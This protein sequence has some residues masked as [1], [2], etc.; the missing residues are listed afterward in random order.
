ME[1][2]LKNLSEKAILKLSGLESFEEGKKYY[3]QGRVTG[4]TETNGL[5]EAT[6]I[7]TDYYKVKISSVDLSVQCT[8]PLFKG[9]IFCKHITA[10]LFTNLKGVVVP[11]KV[12]Q[13]KRP[14]RW[15]N[16]SLEQQFKS[17]I[18]NIP[19]E[20]LISDVAELGHIHPDIEEYFIH[21]YS[22]KTAGFYR[23]LDNQIK[24]KIYSILK[25]RGKHDFANKIFTASREVNSIIQNLPI[26]R[27]SA[28]FLLGAGFWISERLPE[29]NDTNGTL[30]TLISEIIERAC[31]Y[32]NYAVKEDLVLFYQYSSMSSTFGYCKVVIESILRRVSNP[33][34]TEAVITKLEKS[35]YKKD[36][37]FCFSEEC[38]W[39]LMMDYLSYNNQ[40]RYEELLP[41][42]INKTIAIKTGYLN[43]LYRA[44]RYAE[45]L[46]SGAG[47]KDNP[48]ISPAY[49]NSLLALNNKKQIVEYYSERLTGH[50]DMA[51][52]KRFSEIDGI[53]RL[54]QWDEL[55]A[56][57]L[58]AKGNSNYHAELLMYLKRYDDFIAFISF[59]GEEFYRN[60]SQ[61]EKYAVIFSITNAPMAIKLYHYLV[62]RELKKISKTSRYYTLLEY[63]EELK[64]L[65]DFQYLETLKNNLV[66]TYPTRIKL[67]EMLSAF[68][69]KDISL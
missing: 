24:V 6:V 15:N 8:C 27:H 40:A 11:R 47:L 69:I 23:H 26:S 19:R 18:Q 28:E 31:E 22:E 25:Y 51:T 52:F 36:R 38:G 1:K 16:P 56:K 7:G 4:Y 50:F 58:A 49:E 67:L 3:L 57:I 33:E 32:L 12:P 62:D 20:K 29:I 68:Q 9:E 63:F 53:K 30:K 13:I 5:L 34:I 65:N 46:I 45:V 61:I 21:K 54:P 64:T 17:S 55:V 41:E 35:I 66:Q 43:Y 10:L 59:E 2:I 14:G 37:D 44:K 60:N 48:D 42:V 39:E